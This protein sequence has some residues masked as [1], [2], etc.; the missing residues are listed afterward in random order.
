MSPRHYPPGPWP[1]ALPTAT[2]P[3]RRH[4]HDPPLPARMTTTIAQAV[5]DA[6]AR[7]DGITDNPRL[8]ARLLLGHALALS[9]NDLIRDPGRAVD[10]AGFDNLVAR[11]SRREPLA[12]IL[13]QREFWSMAFNVSAA[14]L[15]P[16]PESE[17]LVEAALMAFTDQAPPEQILDL[18]TGTGCLLLALLKEFP[19]AFG[20]GLDLGPEAAKLAGG[21]AA[22][23]GLADRAAFVVGDWMAPV[24]GRFDLIVC[25]PPY[26]TRPDLADLMPE[27][28][29]HEP[30]RALDGGPDGYAAYR[31]IL[32][33]LRNHLT[34]K[35][36]AIIELGF[37]QAIYVSDMARNLGFTAAVRADLAKVPRA[38]VLASL[39]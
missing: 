34:P 4:E 30:R 26:I 18:G 35:G 23:L 17:T 16:R 31:A 32:P 8:E 28:A 12:L 3:R 11:R 10:P 2:T 6:A 15:I 13:G 19:S 22:R 33:D 27:I 25:N 36:V 14:T 5:R 37:G 21:N 9:Q 29:L 38:L 24:A 1:S 20:V 39:N 7:L